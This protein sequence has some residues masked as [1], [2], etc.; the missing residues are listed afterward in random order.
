MIIIAMIYIG[1]RPVFIAVALGS[2]LVW[3]YWARKMAMKDPKLVLVVDIERQEVQPLMCGRKL[4]A[5]ME[6][7]GKPGIALKTPGGL[8]VEIVKVFDP[9]DLKIEYPRDAD[10]SDLQIA[11]AP[12]RYGK[13]I[14]ELVE[15]RMRN[16]ELEMEGK[17][18]TTRDGIKKGQAYAAKLEEIIA[19]TFIPRE[20]DI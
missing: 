2:S 18:A 4:W 5:R 13:L 3:S 1:V 20:K 16:Y 11:A 17:I 6:K 8:S 14:D 19:S 12:E 7:K 10:F 9:Y 15:L